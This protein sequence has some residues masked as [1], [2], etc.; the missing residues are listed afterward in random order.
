MAL[1]SS[2]EPASTSHDVYNNWGIS[3]SFGTQEK[4]L[5]TVGYRTRIS[6]VWRAVQIRET[7]IISY[8]HDT[9]RNRYED[10]TA[11]SHLMLH[12][13][14][15]NPAQRKSESVQ[16][17]THAACVEY[18]TGCRLRFATTVSSLAAISSHPPRSFC[19]RVF[20][21]LEPCKLLRTRDRRL[22]SDRICSWE[23]RIGPSITCI[24]MIVSWLF[25]C[26]FDYGITRFVDS[27]ATEVLGYRYDGEMAVTVRKK[28]LIWRTRLSIR[29]QRWQRRSWHRLAKSLLLDTLSC[30]FVIKLNLR[31]QTIDP[32][33]I[34]TDGIK[35]E[36]IIVPLFLSA[37]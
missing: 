2:G 10:I 33:P 20:R 30:I 36:I 9:L 21:N 32:S 8:N 25:Y 29:S 7:Y 34:P 14:S 28:S 1:R 19:S 4:L 31:L 13:S 16:R 26:S 22:G 18:H 6:G 35:F 37:L 23:S 27:V 15:W 17:T 11:L 24:C 5:C 12:C 3:L